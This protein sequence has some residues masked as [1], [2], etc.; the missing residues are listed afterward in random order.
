MSIFF[1]RCYLILFVFFPITFAIA[2]DEVIIDH[3]SVNVYKTTDQIVL[4]GVFDEAIWQ[5]ITPSSGMNQNFPDDQAK[6]MQDTEVSLAYD[7]DYL[8]IAVTCYAQGNDFITTSL[9]RDYDFFGNDNVTILFDTYNDQTNALVFGMNAHGLR[10]EAT[11]ANAGQSPSDFDDSWDNKWQGAAKQYSDKWTAEMAIPFSTLRFKN[12]SKTWRFNMYRVDTQGN[13]ISS[14]TDIPR[15]RFVMDLGYMGDMIWEEPLQQTGKNISLI[16]YMATNI[17]RDFED[18]MQAGAQRKVSFG[19][20]AKIGISSGL[21][22]DLT[23]NPDFSQVEVDQQVSN[24]DRFELLFPERRQFFL[25]NADLFGSFGNRFNN[26]F[27]SRRIGVDIDPETGQ[28]IQKTILYGARL[29][30]KLNEKLRIGVLNMQTAS[31]EST[32]ESL[33]TPGYNFS[34]ATAEQRIS[35]YSRLKFMGVNKQLVNPGNYNGLHL[36]NYNR[37]LGLEYQLNTPSNKWVATASIQKSFSPNTGGNEYSH[38]AQIVYTKRKY[39]L[40]WAQIMV[41]NN[42][43]PEVGFAPRKDFILM[44]PEG[45]INFYPENGNIASH[46]LGFDSRVFYKLGQDDNPHIRG[47]AIEEFNFDPFWSASFQ[48][49]AMLRIESSYKNLTLLQDFDPT[50]LQED[51]I[52]LSGGTNYSFLENS[53]SYTSDLRKTVST[54]TALNFGTYFNGYRFGAEGSI[55]L[56]YQPYG[57]V[58]LDYSYNKVSLEAPFKT[59]NIWLI[60]PRI[61]LTFTKSIF[62]TTFV[63][64]NNQL[65]NLNINARFQW[66][67]APVSDFFVVYT[68]NYDTGAMSNFG[69]RNRALIAKMTYWFN[70]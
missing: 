10:R 22:L 67:F 27:F 53:I 34:V 6:A 50:R 28:N 11:V 70:L 42:Y 44:S 25:E 21:N 1:L 19:G 43:N 20:D 17:T 7:T 16:P 33:G 5:R 69:S 47:A 40:E 26:P 13:E 62:F 37:L 18:P 3:P 39:R 30:G 56:R 23:V 15:N 66:R 64:Y 51:G 36:N 2:Q 4:D 60:G 48:N 8:Y 12:G 35:T 55:T 24:L 63:Q 65:D 54:S 49:L 68:D 58:S 9:R 31:T 46:S 32:I 59:A 41:G 52:V 61:D 45:E 57:F 29:S 38:T 14:F